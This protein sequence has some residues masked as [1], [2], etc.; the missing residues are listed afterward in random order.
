MNLINFIKTDRGFYLHYS[1]LDGI[2]L[3]QSAFVDDEKNVRFHGEISQDVGLD[4]EG[5][6]MKII[7]TNKYSDDP[8]EVNINAQIGL[9]SIG[10]YNSDNIKLEVSHKL[11]DSYPH[12]VSVRGNKT[13]FKNKST[14]AD[15]VNVTTFHPGEGILNTMIEEAGGIEV[16]HKLAPNLKI[17]GKAGINFTKPEAENI[18]YDGSK[19][20]LGTTYDHSSRFNISGGVGLKHEK[21]PSYQKERGS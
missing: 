20:N 2:T 10:K 9:H 8:D 14:K 5:V 15:V 18:K 7:A 13:L 21:T 19:L 6:K 16:S 1:T 17:Q 3:D 12:A 11:E 4:N